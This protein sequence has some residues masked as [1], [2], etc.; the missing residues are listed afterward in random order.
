VFGVVGNNFYICPMFIRQVKKQ[1][2][3]SSKVFYQY[4]LV[5]AARVNGKVK[6]RSILYLGSDKILEDE[7]NRKTVLEILKSKIFKQPILFEQDISDE[8]QKLASLY[9]DKYCIKYEQ[10]DENPTSIPPRPEVSEFHN[11]DIKGLETE[12]VKE[13]GA[14]YLCKQTLDK[15]ELGNY[16][17]SL[18][19]SDGQSKKAL[20]S[21]VAKAIY[22]APEYK[23]SQIIEMNS[24]LRSLYNYEKKITHKQLYSISDILYKH[25]SSIDKYLYNRITNMFDINDKLVIFDL[26]NTYFETRKTQ[27][28]I[29]KYGRSK[30]KR[31]DCPLVVFSGVINS[32]GFIRHSRI[33][34]GNKSDTATVSDMVKDLEAHSS[35]NIQHTVVIDAGIA[36]DDNLKELDEKGYRYVCVSRNRIKDYTVD[37]SKAKTI[38]LT[39]RGKNKVELSVFKPEG[40]DDTWMYV[41]SEAKRKKESS[42]NLKLRQRFEEDLNSIKA[43]F[44]KKGGTKLINK[45]WERIGRAKQKHNR[46]SARYKL[47]VTEKD[48]EATDLT[49]TIVENKIKDDKSKGVYF[50]RTNY[51]KTEEGELWDIYNIIREVE[52]TFRSLKSDLNLRPVHHQNDERIEAH[53]YLTMLAYQLVNT[54]RYMLKQN[55]CNYDWNNI[56]RIMSTQ[57]IQTIKLP[58][59][60]KV[61]HLRKPSTPIN[62]VRQIYDATNCKHTIQ[63]VKKYV[64]YH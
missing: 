6:Q 23:T 53:L 26:S 7:H 34:E 5:Q 47:N 48:G 21:I 13:F 32:Q 64:V 11:I 39:N 28:K 20:I 40:Y 37:A 55:D 59:D 15:L 4:T 10:A 45:V 50:I 60:K 58:T 46:V 25:K 41:E 49:W 17:T 62:E 14:E 43:S 12:D 22:S 2:S 54:I 38:K 8:L 35:P 18:G 52:A 9:Y 3:S 36:T 61:M 56:L 51:Q 33:Y 27:S 63:A 29:A 42:M 30:E 1:R 16:F 57:K 31:N 24:E 19:M 44:S